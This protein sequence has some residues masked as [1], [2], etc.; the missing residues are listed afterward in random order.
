LTHVP[1]PTVQPLRVLARGRELSALRSGSSEE[2]SR[3]LVIALH[4]AG[5]GAG[6]W[7]YANPGDLS[8]L[9][10]GALLGYEVLALERPGYGAAQDFCADS[11]RLDSQAELLIE[12]IESWLHRS[13]STGHVFV[14]GHS[15]GGALALLM[16]SARPDLIDAVDV[17]G[18]PFRFATTPDGEAVRQLVGAATHLLPIGDDDRKA[19]LFGPAETYDPTALQVDRELVRAMPIREYVDA[20]ELP[21]RWAE[22]LPRITVPVQ[23]TVAAHETMQEAGPSVLEDVRSLLQRCPLVR[24]HEQP[25]TSH[26]ASMAYVATAYH[27][28]ALAFFSEA[29]V[30]SVRRAVACANDVVTT[31]D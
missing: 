18:V 10:L 3:G 15:V 11:C 13:N 30:P 21:T 5:Y 23:Y 16:A 24:L 6:Y 26:N 9:Q 27:L 17:L 1:S 14:I 28:R 19:W 25:H 4:G 20:V 22:V 8:L 29:V 2:P 31:M 7:A 12:A